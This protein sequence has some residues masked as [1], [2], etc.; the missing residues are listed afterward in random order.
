MSHTIDV[1][2]YANYYHK[3]KCFLNMLST[4]LSL[5]QL[6]HIHTIHTYMYAISLSKI[7][8]ELF[9]SFFQ[10]CRICQFHVCRF[11]LKKFF[12]TFYFYFYNFLFLF[13]YFLFF[14]CLSFKFMLKNF[15]ARTQRFNVQTNSTGTSISS[16]QQ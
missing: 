6:T 8:L 5:L 15:S 2:T 14:V 11:L 10:P 16:Q 9:H 3:R 13:I 12:F 1:S 7:Y 4:L